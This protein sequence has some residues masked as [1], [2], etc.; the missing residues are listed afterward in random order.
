MHGGEITIESTYGVESNFIIKLQITTVD[1]T[2]ENNGFSIN[3]DYVD[4]MNIEFS[5]SDERV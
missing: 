5:E 4:E 3:E 2:K 1:E